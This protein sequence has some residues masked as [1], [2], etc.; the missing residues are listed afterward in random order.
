MDV[1]LAPA[2]FNNLGSEFKKPGDTVRIAKEMRADEIPSEKKM[3]IG[4]AVHLHDA[5]RECSLH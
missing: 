3:L 5:E 2:V 1:P 4:R